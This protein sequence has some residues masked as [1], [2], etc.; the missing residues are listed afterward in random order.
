MACTGH[1]IRVWQAITAGKAFSSTQEESPRYAALTHREKPRKRGLYVW[2]RME[3]PCGNATIHRLTAPAARS[4]R[5]PTADM[6]LQETFNVERARIR[7]PCYELMQAARC[8]SAQRMD[9]LE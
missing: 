7:L 2:G 8:V 5:Y 3:P 1:T 4:L 9:R 6:R